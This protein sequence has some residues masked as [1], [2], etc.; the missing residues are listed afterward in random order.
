MKVAALV[1]GV[2]GGLAGLMVGYFCSAVLT[3]LAETLGWDRGGF[4]QAMAVAIA[5]PIAGIAGGRMTHSRSILAGVLMSISAVGT[6][7]IFGIN[8]LGIIPVALTGVGALFAFL[9]RFSEAA[10]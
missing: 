1:C 3:G 5:L 6:A 9:S 10:N 2:L 4:Y 8:S 7:L